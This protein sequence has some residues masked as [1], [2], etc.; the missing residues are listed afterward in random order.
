MN[1]VPG[2][3]GDRLL[4]N[5]RAFRNRP[6]QLL[7]QCR[8][9]YGDVV[10]LRLGPFSVYLVFNPQ[11]IVRVF[12]DKSF[13]RSDFSALFEPLAGGSMIIADGEQWLRQRHR[14]A[15]AFNKNR[16]A[17]L[18]PQIHK[19]AVEI[20]EQWETEQQAGHLID[21]QE[22][23]VG[24]AMKVIT[25]F[26]FGSG[27]DN[28]MLVAVAKAWSMSLKSMNYRMSEALPLPLWVPT[29]NNRHLR[30]AA[31]EISKIILDIIAQQR[32]TPDDSG[33]FLSTLLHNR[34]Q[35]SEL[36]DQEILHEIMGIFLAGFDT[37]AIAMVWTLYYLARYPD[38]QTQV[39]QEMLTTL[40]E[41]KEGHLGFANLPYFDNVFSEAIRLRPPLWLVDRKSSTETELG[42][43]HIPPNSN[44]IL[45]PYVTHRDSRFWDNPAVF[46]PARFEHTEE[47]EK[48]AYFPFG[49]GHMRCIGIGLT[50]LEAQIII[51]EILKRYRIELS[52]LHPVEIDCLFV[53]RSKEG[54]WMRLT[55]LNY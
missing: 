30:S 28:K 27:L 51:G 46:N 6:L 50:K 40:K 7:L 49:G 39:R 1:T 54:L 26:L 19:N 31:N 45:S 53:L 33:S 16:L 47:R 37:V 12:D 15:P 35:D 17:M 3:H 29:R 42:G 38:I 8:C 25:H 14:V 9:E 44:I 48:Y 21:V 23:M 36:K 20:V 34:D 22:A 2:P 5:L 13:G 10:K 32:K 52:A 4:G 24:Y 55:H 41:T 43:Y 11:D 18:A